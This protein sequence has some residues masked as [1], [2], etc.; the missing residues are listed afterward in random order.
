MKFLLISL[1]FSTSV[2]SAWDQPQV[3]CPEEILPRGI[4]CLDLSSVVNIWDEFP[5]SLS[6]QEIHEWKTTYASDLK[7]CRHREVLRREAQFPG[8]FTPLQQQIAW[9]VSNGGEDAPEKLTEVLATSKTY[10]IPPQILLGAI[11]QESL[12]ASLGIS[13]DGGNY[14]CG[15]AQLNLSEWCEA[16][17]TRSAE[18]RLQLG[19]PAVSCSSLTPALVEPFFN[20]A[21]TKLG[22][23]PEYQIDSSDFE[24]ITISDVGMTS[25]AKY[26]ATTSFIRHCQD[27]SLSIR[28]KGRTL[29]NIYDRFVPSQ[30][31]SQESYSAGTTFNRQCAFRYTSTAYPLQT[32]WLL[33]VG[34]Y[35][36]GP[37]QSKIIEHYYG[38]QNNVYPK[39]NPLNLIEALHWGG[40][41]RPGSRNVYFTGQDG[42]MRSQPWYKSCV[43]QR[44]VARVI[45]HVT[46]PGLTLARSLEKTACSYDVPAYRRT[47]SG[48]KPN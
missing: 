35:N 10:N 33:A 1:L 43:V 48:V 9:M 41:Y 39:M 32:G 6:A 11:T 16:M 3:L 2:F 40:V 30:I 29:R 8:S 14:S 4:Q 21:K 47:S 15:I 28:F 38:V 42:E 23:R 12:L 22:S 26:R 17:A 34:M 37:R 20:I 7:L 31:R 24:N 19:W 13:P 45:Q 27:I 18:E 36:A 25:E 5:L 44:H 46:I